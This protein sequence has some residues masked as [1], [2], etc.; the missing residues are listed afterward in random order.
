MVTLAPQ[1]GSAEAGSDD[2]SLIDR[3]VRDGARRML[4]AALEAEVAVYVEAFAEERDERGRRLVVRNGFLPQRSIHT[5]IGPV[6]V[7]QPRIEDRQADDGREQFSS[8]ILPPYLRRT[9]NI[10]E[11]IPWLYLKGVST[12]DF[13]EALSALRDVIAYSRAQNGRWFG[14]VQGLRLRSRQGQRFNHGGHEG[15]GG[16]RRLS[17]HSLVFSIL[18]TFSSSEM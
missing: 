16:M 10:E 5:G 14:Y 4:A 9:K 3:I 8:K 1:D 6:A 11:L 15:H 2:A 18:Y 17:R 7:R 13:P 12:N